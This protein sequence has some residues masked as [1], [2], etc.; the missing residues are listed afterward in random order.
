[1]KKFIKPLLVAIIFLIMQG[2][3]GGI[4]G[5]IL[6]I[7]KPEFLEAVKAGNEAEITSAIPASWLAYTIDVSGILTV[8]IASAMKLINWN[9]VFCWDKKQASKSWLPLI[10]A[11]AGI[12]SIAVFEEN[13]QLEDELA[14][15]FASMMHSVVGIISISIVGPI[16]EELCFREAIMGG[17]LRKGVKPWVAIGLSAAIFGLIH[18]NPVQIVGAGLMGVIFGIVYYKSGNIILSSVLH[19]LNNS[20]ATFIALTY[21]METSL[22][23]IFGSNTITIVSGIICAI[24][25]IALFVRYWKCEKLN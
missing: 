17:L 4:T 2:V 3:A 1:M 10:A 24:F 15:Q 22:S 20:F 13:L 8:I 25:S 6:V 12:F 9:T 5:L 23:D 14:E 19:I 11:I 7:T 18:G 21:G 16:I